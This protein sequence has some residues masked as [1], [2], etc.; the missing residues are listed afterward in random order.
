[1]AEKKQA[2]ARGIA[3]KVGKYSGKSVKVEFTEVRKSGGGSKPSRMKGGKVRKP[4]PT[5]RSRRKHTK[6]DD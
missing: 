1:M 5:I 4:T 3:A 2:R 6:I